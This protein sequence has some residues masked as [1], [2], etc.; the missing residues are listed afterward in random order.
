MDL[1]SLRNLEAFKREATRVLVKLFLSEY[2]FYV[3][4]QKDPATGKTKL[5]DF[6]ESEKRLGLN[7]AFFTDKNVLEHPATRSF[8]QG[9]ES[10]AVK[11]SDFMTLR[12][13]LHSPLCHLYWRQ[14]RVK[15]L[16]FV[17]VPGRGGSAAIGV[18]NAAKD[19]IESDRQMMSL[20]PPHFDQARR[21]AELFDRIHQHIP[22]KPVPGSLTP[23]E[24]EIAHWMARGKLNPE[25]AIILNMN[26]RT[27]EKHVEN[28]LGKLGVENR[29]AAA[30][31]MTSASYFAGQ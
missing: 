1:Y 10:R 9:G 24:T 22:S 16:L 17:S 29:T 2:G 30:V 27:V 6:W 15:R 26:T 21:T 13:F 14:M 20:I 4:Y 12:Q 31:V 8:L 28:I 25:I 3:E 11:L 18:A 23:R 19:F 5:T 7:T